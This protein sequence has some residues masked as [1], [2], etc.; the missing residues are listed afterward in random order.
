MRV[1]SRPFKRRGGLTRG[2]QVRYR[3][4]VS[5]SKRRPRPASFEAALRAIT[6]LRCVEAPASVGRALGVTG[7][8]SVRARVLGLEFD[9]T[10]VQSR[11][12]GHRLFIP[13]TVWKARGLALGDIIPVEVW[14]VKPAAVRMPPELAA[15]AKG[16]P[17]LKE[18]YHQI[19]PSDRRQVEKH[20]SSLVSPESRRQF[21]ERLAKRLLSPPPR[22]R[23][24]RKAS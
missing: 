3:P 11:L 1:K 13:S 14:R 22:K 5:A 2:F 15:L 10:L 20:L 16:T 24:P 12:G 23:R 19:T 17:A 9:N 8:A 21:A 6:V 7:K 18:C 4:T